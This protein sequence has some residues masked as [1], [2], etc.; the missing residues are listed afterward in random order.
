MNQ[1]ISDNSEILTALV[2]I[3]LGGIIRGIEKH[4]LRRKGKLNDQDKDQDE[5]FNPEKKNI[6]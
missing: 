5:E 4:R 3:I 2:T 6:E 1:A